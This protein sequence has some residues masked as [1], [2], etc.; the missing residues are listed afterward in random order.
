MDS[1]SAKRFVRALRAAQELLT[2]DARCYC[3]T[4]EK[5]YQEVIEDLE[6]SIRMLEDGEEFAGKLLFKNARKLSPKT[7]RALAQRASAPEERE[8]YDF[9]AELNSRQTRPSAGNAETGPKAQG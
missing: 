3:F 7:A 5:D 2:G 6:F 9:I 8:F 1:L 4:N